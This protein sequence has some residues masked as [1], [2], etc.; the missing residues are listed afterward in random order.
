MHASQLIDDRDAA[1]K[2]NLLLYKKAAARAALCSVC[3][4]CCVLER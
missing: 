3:M 4:L 1:P 2:I